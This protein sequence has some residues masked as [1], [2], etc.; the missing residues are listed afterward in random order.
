MNSHQNDETTRSNS[1]VEKTRSLAVAED[2]RARIE[3]RE[4]STGDRLPGEHALAKEYSVSRATLRTAL[5]DLESRGLT[6]TVHGRGTIVAA[7]T[8]D[9]IDIRRLESMATTIGNTGRRATSEYRSVAMRPAT[10]DEH[11]RLSLDESSEVLATERVIFAD[12]EPV[13]YSFDVIP[14]HILTESFSIHDV[15]GSLF[16]L[17]EQHGVRAIVAV[18]TINSVAGS[19]IPFRPHQPHPTYLVMDQLHSDSAARPVALAKTYFVEGHFN[20]GLIR[21]R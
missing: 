15:K 8:P 19:D 16:D 10:T 5:R 9:M 17:L 18:T 2:L 3:R 7:T 6:F 13:A 12:R 20:F 11:E 14:T 21:H 1:V 4:W